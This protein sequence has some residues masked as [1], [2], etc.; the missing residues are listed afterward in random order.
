M[1]SVHVTQRSAGTFSI[2]YR[3][4]TD[5]VTGKRIEKRETFTPEDAVRERIP[6]KLER[7]KRWAEQRLSE[8]QR[9]RE[10][11]STGADQTLGEWVNYWIDH[12][13]SG[14]VK[15]ERTRA[16]YFEN[17]RW[18]IMPYPI[19]S[20]R[21]RD[22]TGLKV[23]EH[24]AMLQR[25]G[26]RKTGEGLSPRTCV[27]VQQALRRALKAAVAGRLIPSNPATSEH[28]EAISVP[29]H[30]VRVCSLD[31]LAALL[32]RL[33]GHSKEVPFATAIFLGL[34]RGEVCGI[35]LDDVRLDASPATLTVRWAL[36]YYG[37]MVRDDDGK[38]RRVSRM[39]LKEPKSEAGKRTLEIPAALAES[40]RV[41]ISTQQ[42]YWDALGM[43][44]PAME[45]PD[46]S[47]HRPLFHNL[48][49]G[50]V[51][52]ENLSK[53]FT[54]QCRKAGIPEATMHTMRHSFVT[55]L[56]NRP[57]V[58]LKAVA[59]AAGHG[60]VR[61]TQLVYWHLTEEARADASAAIHDE[62]ER[63]ASGIVIPMRRG[64]KAS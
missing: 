1:A 61:V 5:P 23:Q 31:E 43:P 47:M 15:G 48:E 12:I 39:F 56:L 2:R 3:L 24:L 58:T 42:A 20:V 44:W 34:R 28:V 27:H 35:G 11:T 54:R 50:Y 8:Q 63:L 4:G 52:P 38:L 41:H 26:H 9:E 51:H 40:I 62:S 46:G 18:H 45:A 14:V 21:L 6:F 16:H 49:G 13:A 53:E 25:R 36:S 7:V 60:D 32:R 59:A 29:K 22:L 30:E 33:K 17:L 19:S 57:D 55:R 37:E 10:R 64:P